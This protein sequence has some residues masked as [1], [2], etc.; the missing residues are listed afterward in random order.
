MKNLR[1][2]PKLDIKNYNLVK[3]ISM[4]GFRVL[5]DPKKFIE[6]YYINGADEIIYH[7][8][9]ASLYNRKQ[10]LSLVERTAENTFLPITI[11]GGIKDIEDIKNFLNSG[12]DRVFINSSFV[13]NKKF[14]RESINHFGSSTILGSVEVHRENKDYFCYI[15][16]G[17]EETK[18]KFED[19]T[20]ELQDN[21][22]SEL[23]ITSID[24]DGKGKG[25]D[26]F[27]AEI[28]QKIVKVPYIINGGFGELFHFD[29]LLDVCDPN[30]IALGSMLHYGFL[31]SPIG[32]EEGNISFLKNKKKFMNFGNYNLSEIKSHLLKR[33][34]VRPLV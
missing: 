1:I 34:N 32:N 33:K 13:R 16:F 6:N 19:W 11:G 8:T 5:G 20:L 29:Q 31:N 2:I 27:L 24:Q 10:L 21:G 15:D 7:D 14:I 17:R 12:A 9:V 26:L 18:L 4:E 25:F 23:I 3:G 28:I 22:I 30:G